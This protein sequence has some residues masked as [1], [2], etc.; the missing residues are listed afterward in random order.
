MVVAG[1]GKRGTLGVVRTAPGA[2]SRKA[3]MMQTEPKV[4]HVPDDSELAQLLEASDD[5]P[6]LLERRGR[7]YR[8]D[9][10][11]TQPIPP[12]E[13]VTGEELVRR[14]QGLFRDIDTEQLKRDIYEA[15]GQDSEGRPA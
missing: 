6:V 12:R 11:S 15:R 3:H 9:L 5:A 7:R 8:V 10:D 4:Y 1:N 14:M 13:Q 2:I